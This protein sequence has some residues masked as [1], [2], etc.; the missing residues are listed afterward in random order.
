MSEA[1]ATILV[2]RKASKGKDVLRINR[3][4]AECGIADILAFW[5]PMAMKKSILKRKPGRPRTTGPGQQIKLRCHRD[6]LQAVDYWRAKQN[7]E[8]VSRPKAIMQL[9]WLALLDARK[10]SS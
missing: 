9:A 10:R 7:G 4:G 3:I 1:T 5:P 2:P 8:R 6:F